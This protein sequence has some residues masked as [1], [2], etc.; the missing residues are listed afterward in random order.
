[1]ISAELRAKIRRLFFAEHWRIGT[2]VSQLSVHR[3]TVEAAIEP[4]QFANTRFRET[5]GLLDP[6]KSFITSTLETY[7]RLRATRLHDMLQDR[8]YK[9]T[10][11]PVRR[12]VRKVRPVAKHEAFFRLTMLPGEQ[13]QVDWGSFGTVRIGYA[14]RKLSCFLLT[15]SWSRWLWAR[16]TLD[17]TLESFVRCHVLAFE[18]LGGVLRQLLYDNL[19]SAVLE[20]VD[21]DLIRFHPQM[22][23]LAGH[24]HFVPTLCG[25]ARGNEKGRVERRVRDLREAFFEARTFSSVDDL[26]AQLATWLERVQRERP[27]PDDPD[28]RKVRDAFAQERDVFLPLPE[29]RFVCDYVKPTKSG[30][31]PYVRFDRNDY[32]I[33]HTHV[34][35]V[36]S[37]VASDTHVRV[38]DGLAVL[39]DHERSYDAGRCI[40]DPRHL[41]DLAA[42]K[43]RARQQRGR[44]RVIAACPAAR[45]FLESIALHGGHLGGTTARLLR[46]L[47]QYGPLSLDAALAQAHERAAFSAHSVAHILEQRRRVTG[48]PPPIAIAL[49]DDP[50][51]RDTVVVPHSLGEYDLLADR[52]ASHDD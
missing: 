37:L 14:V 36:V 40:E 26:N 29:H 46:L 51:V 39:A 5:M 10:V 11:Y 33:P 41:E 28:H 4:K 43:R 44:H 13:A 15:L 24:Y 27:V 47:D 45:P 6:Y 20:R 48:A 2:I 21:D 7:P 32:S 30:K 8:G 38:L 18:A 1:M 49:P 22:L 12:Y 3:D 52:K 16:F 19:K 35:K 31:T 9:G 25:K 34:R 50:R 23:A 42:Y 17:Q